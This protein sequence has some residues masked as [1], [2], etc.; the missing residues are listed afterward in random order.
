MRRGGRIRDRRDGEEEE[1]Q[2]RG[3]LGVWREAMEGQG[4]P[5][6]PISIRVPKET[7]RLVVGEPEY[8][9]PGRSRTGQRYI[10]KPTAAAKG[11]RP[12]CSR[13]IYKITHARFMVSLMVWGFRYGLRF[14]V[15]LG[16]FSLSVTFS[17]RSLLL[18][19]LFGFLSPHF[20]PV[21]IVPV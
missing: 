7:T 15:W 21:I 9:R 6:A 4:R 18:G 14:L 16:R 20:F 1:D 17:A 3:G 2:G 8:D 12:A 19:L 5:Q 13:I 11:L 10:E